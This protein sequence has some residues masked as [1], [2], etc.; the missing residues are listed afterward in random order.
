ML[1]FYIT[2]ITYMNKNFELR[3]CFLLGKQEL[4]YCFPAKQL[5]LLYKR[6]EISIKVFV[7][8]KEMAL[9]NI[10]QRYF[11]NIPQLLCL[12]YIE[13][14]IRTKVVEIWKK[15]E[16]EA[17]TIATTDKEIKKI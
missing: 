2:S 12:W 13:K 8:D 5:Y 7:T 11:P 4:N 10:L 14:N 9:K 3:Y 15:Q 17:L 16:E 6:L 1:F